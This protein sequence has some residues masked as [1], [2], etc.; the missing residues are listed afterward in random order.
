M[1]HYKDTENKLHFIEGESF[2]HLLPP[3]CVRV[4]DAEAEGLRNPPLTNEQIV[5]TFVAN[6]ERRYDAVAQA[7]HYDNRFTCALRAG[8]AGPFQAEGQAFAVWM[9]AC[10]AYG[11][12]EMAKVQNGTRP[13]PTI[14][15]L[16]SE[17]PVA[18]W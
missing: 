1:P 5:A 16:L 2:A 6:M 7:K 8:Y 10:N 9:D 18:P 12:Q 14:E 4:T 11:Y 13:M 15:Q 17:L 3:G